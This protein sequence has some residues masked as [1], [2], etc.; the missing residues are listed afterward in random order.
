MIER[1][2]AAGAT[3]DLFS[4]DGFVAA[5]MVV[6]AIREGGDDVDG[7]IA[8]LEGWTFE[9][10]KGTT[11]I[12]A[13]DHAVLQPMFQARLVEQGGSWV[14]ELIEIVEA[15]TVAPPVVG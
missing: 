9:G 6:Q 1:L 8:A 12:R 13:E 7:M 3:P 10:P 11:T 4:P 15:D 14:P 2:D 5:Q